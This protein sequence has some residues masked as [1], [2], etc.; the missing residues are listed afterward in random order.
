MAAR[1]QLEFFVLRYVPDAVKGEFVNVGIVAVE[2][3]GGFAD[4]RFTRDWRR[5]QCLDP[6]L[7]IEVLE[8][9]ER[10][11]RG[12]IAS[13]P[14]REAFLKRLQD[15]FSNLVQLSPV[16]G[17]LAE[18]PAREMDELSTLYLESKRLG[19]RMPSTR[20]II[21]QTMADAFQ[22]AGV[23]ERMARAVNV[24][25]YTWPNDPLKIDFSYDVGSMRKMFQAMPARSST[26]TV[27]G[28]AF[29]FPKIKDAMLRAERIEVR[30]TGVIEDDASRDDE[31]GFVLQVMKESRIEIA[32]VGTMPQIAELARQELR[33]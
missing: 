27:L 30:L 20:M 33:A 8:A 25:A 29:R 6:E 23:L 19:K 28:L 17:C 16:A 22:Q 4:V 24:A 15:S 12:Q 21:H 5:A 26:D 10:E 14:D 31:A 3:D 18:D 32:T 11:I 1:R 7:D 13:V 9:L 2:A